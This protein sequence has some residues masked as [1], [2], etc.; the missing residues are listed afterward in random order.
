MVN[1]T[2]LKKFTKEASLPLGLIVAYFFIFHFQKFISIPSQDKFLGL[3]VSFINHQSLL[4][5]FVIALFE[6]GLVLGQYVPGGVV[7]FLSILAAQG[8]F[9]KI[10]LLVLVVSAAYTI[11]YTFDYFIGYYG[12]SPIVEKIG[13]GKYISKYKRRLEK[14]E[15]M[16]IFFTYWETNVASIVAAASGSLKIPFRKFFTYSLIS[17]L[18]W[19]I[20]WATL[21]VIFG[22]VVLEFVGY[23]YLLIVVSIWL[24]VIFYRNFIKKEHLPES[25]NSTTVNL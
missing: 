3:I 1:K 18:F 7:I 11:A 14:H 21:L 10:T 12:I 8:H 25:E 17:V 22:N 16:T 6:G 19:N 20:F 2:K 24:I 5:I 15:F 23:R 9:L 4:T 13:F